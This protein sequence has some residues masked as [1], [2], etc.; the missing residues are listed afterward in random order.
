M[1]VRAARTL[2]AWNGC[3]EITTE[4]LSQAARLV[5]PH[6]MRRQPLESVGRAV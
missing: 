4:D 3:T 2:A 1:M 6:R 5:L